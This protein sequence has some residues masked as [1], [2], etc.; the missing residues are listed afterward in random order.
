MAKLT[1]AAR[2]ALPAADFAGPG[3]SYPIQDK[4]HAIAAKGRATQF[5]PPAL[6][7]KVD[8]K[9]NKVLHKADGGAV[10]MNTMNAAPMLQGNPKHNPDNRLPRKA[11]HVR[12]RNR[13]M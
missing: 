3:R 5:A 4:A 1:T 2:N 7:A 12:G 8:A 11:L 10:G 6:K 13:G 9:A